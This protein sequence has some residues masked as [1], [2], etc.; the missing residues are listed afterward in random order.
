MNRF[1]VILFFCFSFFLVQKVHADSHSELSEIVM[2][3]LGSLQKD[4][5]GYRISLQTSSLRCVAVGDFPYG[6]CHVKGQFPDAGGP[7][8]AH[9]AVVVTVNDEGVYGFKVL[10]MVSWD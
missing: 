10:E 1:Y 4:V 2:S 8:G 7:N 3:N 9:F 6:L 5:D